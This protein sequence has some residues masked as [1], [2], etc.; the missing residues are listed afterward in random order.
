M[1]CAE[2]SSHGSFVLTSPT[3]LHRVHCRFLLLW[4]TLSRTE[5]HPAQGYVC[6]S[7]PCWQRVFDPRRSP[8]TGWSWFL[9]RGRRPLMVCWWSSLNTCRTGIWQNHE[10]IC[11]NWF[12]LERREKLNAYLCFCWSTGSKT[13]FRP[14]TI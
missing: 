4:C 3:L 7:C 6:A 11:N 10:N 2:Q 12:P 5:T 9:H 1:S 8:L 14:N 13:A